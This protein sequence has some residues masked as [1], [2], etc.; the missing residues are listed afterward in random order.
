MAES[1][2]MRTYTFLDALQPQFASFIATV[3][4]GFLPLENQAALFVEIS[5]GLHINV[6]TDQVLKKT[7]VI[8]GM[9]VV[10]RAYGLLEVHHED[11]GQVREAGRAILDHLGLKEESRL[12]PRI[13]SSQIITGVDNHQTHLINRMRHGQ[14]LLQN[15]TLYILEVHPAGYAAIAANEAEKASPIN[16]LE[17]E[18][19]GAS[20]RLYLGGPEDNIRE[21]S[22]AIEKTLQGLDGRPNEGRSSI[23]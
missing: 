3:A 10:E 20:G 2:E 4:R 9:Q 11:Q 17:V 16:L 5:P 14:F 1:L 6:L 19:F 8:P 18:T 22:Y 15:E 23:Y 13:L 12:K 7:K 21:A